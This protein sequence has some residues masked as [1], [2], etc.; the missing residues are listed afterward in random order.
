MHQPL[1]VMQTGRAIGQGQSMTAKNLPAEIIKL[2][3]YFSVGFE[4][5]PDKHFNLL[6]VSFF[7]GNL[8]FSTVPTFVL[9]SMLLE[10]CPSN[11]Y[12]AELFHVN[13]RNNG[14]FIKLIFCATGTSLAETKNTLSSAWA[15]ST[16]FS[17]S[18][19][20]LMF[21]SRCWFFT[22]IK[23][24][25]KGTCTVTKLRL[26]SQNL[27]WFQNIRELKQRRWQWQQEKKKSNSFKLA[28][29]QLCM[30][31]TLSCKFVYHHCTITTWKGQNGKDGNS[32]Q[33]LSFLFPNF[34]TV[35]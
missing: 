23:G 6:P 3:E 25:K 24:N 11:N 27:V 26:N 14:I 1:Y 28:K 13:I 5:H 32:R 19:K 2:T 7:I 12:F 10:N 35:L 33:Q 8:L 20:K 18:T 22:C 15:L 31:I 4:L 9:Y 29:Q 21:L 34:D 16:H 30:C 17:S